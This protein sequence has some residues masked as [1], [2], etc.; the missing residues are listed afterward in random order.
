M[1]SPVDRVKKSWATA[2]TA[3]LVGLAILPGCSTDAPEAGSVSVG[4]K[5]VVQPGVPP[6]A[7]APKAPKRGGVAPKSIK[8]VSAQP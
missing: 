8:D 5:D 7:G 3:V 1:G 2:A 6:G 4:G